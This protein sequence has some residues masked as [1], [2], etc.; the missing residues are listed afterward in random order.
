MNNSSSEVSVPFENVD[1]DLASYSIEI[2][3]GVVG[4]I[5]NLVQ[6][7]VLFRSRSKCT[8][9][10][11]N[12][13]SLSAA[14]FISSLCYVGFGVDGI[15]DLEMSV[16]HSKIGWFEMI[17]PALFRT[18][19][20]LSFTHVLMIAAQRLMASIHPFKFRL[21]FTKGK[22]IS[23]IVLL[24]AVNIT[25]GILHYYQ[26][27]PTNAILIYSIFFCDLSLTIL[28]S[29]LS[30]LLKRRSKDTAS[31]SANNSRQ[32]ETSRKVF[33]H[34]VC[35]TLVFVVT[36]LPLALRLFV[37]PPP[38]LNTLNDILPPIT[39]VLNNLIYFVYGRRKRPSPNRRIH[40]MGRSVDSIYLED[41]S[42]DGDRERT[43][44]ERNKDVAG[45][46]QKREMQEQSMGRID[47]KEQKRQ[48]TSIGEET[49]M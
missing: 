18:A 6:F 19:V 33:W 24:W 48:S 27:G 36:T 7:I 4:L 30:C 26:I 5:L 37:K 22:L 16:A 46:K 13:Q 9:F 35:V 25:Y 45:K 31:M 10:E 43:K 42:F 40:N 1:L 28:Y 21:L 39:A 11:L 8:L 34:S 32:A 17:S 3:L 12:L 41:Q 15:Y 47:T 29:M 23:C 20:M 44:L 14:D 38:V 2:V 49:C